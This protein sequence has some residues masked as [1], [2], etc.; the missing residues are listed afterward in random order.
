MTVRLGD[1]LL[2]RQLIQ[3]DQLETALRDQLRSRRFLGEILITLGFIKSDSFYPALADYLGLPYVDLSLQIDCIEHPKGWVQIKTTVKNEAHVGL[4]DPQ[5]LFIQSELKQTYSDQKIIYY[6]S[7]PREIRR[8]TH[9]GSTEVSCQ[10]YAP[11]LLRFLVR[12]SLELKASDLHFSPARHHCQVLVRLDGILV[13]LRTLHGDQWRAVCAHIKVLSHM[14]L[15]ESRRP[16]DGSFS[17]SQANDPVDCRVSI[18]PTKDGESAVIRLLDPARVK[19]G[20]NHLGLVQDQIHSLRKIASLSEGLFIITGPTGS[21][22]T[23]TL[24]SLLQEILPSGRNVMTLEDPIEYRLE[25]VRQTQ[26]HQDVT[27]FSDAL[28]SILRHDPDVIYISEIR[29]QETAMTAVRAAMTGHLVLTTLHVSDVRLIPRRLEDLGIPTGYLAGVLK[30]GMA[31]RLIRRVCDACAGCGCESCLETG[32]KGRLPIAEI[33]AQG[34]DLGKQYQT[35]P[36]ERFSYYAQQLVMKNL[37][38]YEEIE[39]VFGQQM[40]RLADVA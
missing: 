2:D 4:A 24:Y 15:A 5:D 26:I 31:Q 1:Y 30:G 20:I 25:G 22:K 16:Q 3:S 12:Q 38:T 32:Y 11:D 27:E 40:R 34:D 14:D 37:T 13:P 19:L 8:L 7:D 35:N 36:R 17:F 6:V 9:A 21:G 28:R 39:R 33:F 10:D 18:M 23:T 29:D